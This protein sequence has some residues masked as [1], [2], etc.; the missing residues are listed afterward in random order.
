MRDNSFTSSL[1]KFGKALKDGG[2]MLSRCS[3]T[4]LNGT[5]E[6]MVQVGTPASFPH[7][8]VGLP[9][10]VHAIEPLGVGKATCD[11]QVLPADMPIVV[12]GA[13]KAHSYV[14][15]TAPAWLFVV[16]NTAIVPLTVQSAPVG[17]TPWVVP[18]SLH[19]ATI[20]SGPRY[21]GT[22][23]ERGPEEPVDAFCTFV[24]GVITGL[25]VNGSL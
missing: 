13:T 15:I 25:V 18:P 11:S 9:V 19:I 6:V 1:P 12:L 14:W 24:R 16:P 20:V 17:T 21:R 2:P 4:P 5:Y 7:M 22:E 23:R 10:A 8:G 3:K